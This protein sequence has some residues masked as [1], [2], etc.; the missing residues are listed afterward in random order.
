MG[1]PSQL[2]LRGGPSGFRTCTCP[3]RGY[4]NSKTLWWGAFSR[5]CAQMSLA[6]C[7]VVASIKSRSV[8]EMLG[9]SIRRL[10]KLQQRAW[11]SECAL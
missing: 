5:Q 8:L 4:W 11:H 7:G 2:T 1:A 10:P 3:G 9:G 6:L